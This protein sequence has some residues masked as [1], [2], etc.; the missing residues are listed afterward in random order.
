MKLPR[1]PNAAQNG[2]RPTTPAQECANCAGRSPPTRR[3]V[4]EIARAVIPL[5]E[6]VGEA[7]AVAVESDCHAFVGEAD[8]FV[9]AVPA[10]A[11]V[12]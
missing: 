5:F 7:H 9:G 2:G 4:R 3:Y 12:G 1:A 10:P 8:L 6:S 11:G